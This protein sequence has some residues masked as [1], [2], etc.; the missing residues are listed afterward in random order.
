MNQNNNDQHLQNDPFSDRG[1]N[2]YS[3]NNYQLPPEMGMMEAVNACFDKYADFEGRSRRS[4][5][6]YFRLFQLIVILG[7]MMFALIGAAIHEFVTFI[8]AGLAF[9]FIIATLIP[10]LAVTVRRFHDTGQSGWLLLLDIFCTSGV[11]TII[12]GCMDSKPGHNQYGPN[13]KGI[14]ND[15]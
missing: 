12:F 7:L 15:W 1:N 14:A 10:A 5:F 6:W 2:N 8:F 11:I 13:P 4:E 3:N 9:L